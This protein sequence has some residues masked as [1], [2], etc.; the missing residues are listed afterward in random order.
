MGVGRSYR[1]RR[2]FDGRAM[3]EE[4]D[5]RIE[6]DDGLLSAVREAT[7]D[8]VCDFDLT[9]SVGDVTALP[10]LIDAH[11][12]LVWDASQAPHEVVEQQARSMTV[13][14]A[15][16][17]A[18]DHLESGVTTVR[19][20]GSTAAVAVDV[21]RAVDERVVRGARV[22][23]AG[24]AIVMTGGHAWWVGREADGVDAV[25]R[26]ARLELK[27]GA[28]CIKLMAS[29]GVYGHAEGIGVP[30]LTVEE[31]RAGVEVAHLAGIPATVHAYSAQAIQ[32]ALD[33]G[34]DAVEHASFM[35]EEQA[36]EMS[37]RGVFMVPTLSVY[38]AM[39]K[40]AVELDLPN[41]MREKTE[42]VLC[43]AGNAFR[44]ALKHRVPLAAGTDA[45]APGHAHRGALHAE[46][47]AMVDA[48]A[49]PIEA[50]T[51]ATSNAARLLAIANDVGT[52]EPGKRADITFV[53]GD[54][55]SD[56]SCLRDVRFVVQ[57]GQAVAPLQP[58][59]AART[60]SVSPTVPA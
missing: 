7:D 35:T 56:I 55:S 9:E 45:G 3:S 1:V 44:L 16:K 40:A 4:G 36:I 42:Q 14:R 11:V 32:N 46:L 13:L 48:G 57:E 47:E 28:R 38:L 31:L 12:H 18:A 33:A 53:A 41:Y 5:Y 21:G 37:R 43:G 10:G 60:Q 49:A 20:V 52:L 8:E 26:A 2:V 22:V 30:Q 25:R 54:P 19:D 39:K 24:R 51:F 15:A 6:T 17:H 29:G 23:A 27:G 34:I 50:L 59:P 58:I